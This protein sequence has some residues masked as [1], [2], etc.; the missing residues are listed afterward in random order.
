MLLEVVIDELIG[1]ERSSIGH[2][3]NSTAERLPRWN[4]RAWRH[5]GQ[6][7]LS[8]KAGANWITSVILFT[9]LDTDPVEQFPI[10]GADLPPR[11]SIFV[12]VL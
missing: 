4:S 7:L 9:A 2:V 1:S 10:L 12:A 5:L 11:D 6:G 3:A 8:G